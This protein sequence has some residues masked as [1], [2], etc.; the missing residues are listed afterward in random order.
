MFDFKVLFFYFSPSTQE[1]IKKDYSKSKASSKQNKIKNSKSKEEPSIRLIED[2][3][4]VPSKP[5]KCK[6]SRKDKN[7]NKTVSWFFSFLNLLDC[8]ICLR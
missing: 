4:D 2:V 3:D 8:N 7:K 5:V 1:S 6:S